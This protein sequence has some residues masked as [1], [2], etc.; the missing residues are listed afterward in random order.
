VQVFVH[1][2][3]FYGYHGVPE[4]ERAVG[5]RY[6][7]DVEL[8]VSDQASLSDRIE[9]T[10]DYGAVGAMVLENGAKPGIATVER[11]A[12]LIAESILERFPSV[13]QVTVTVAKPYPPMPVIAQQA[14]VTLTVGR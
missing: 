1:G 4:A 6:L 14:G 9:D 2:I 5:H 13:K 10:V 3:E 8:D 12:R 11:L 7:V